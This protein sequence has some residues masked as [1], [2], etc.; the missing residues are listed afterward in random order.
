MQKGKALKAG[1]RIALIAPSGPVAVAGRMEKA[2]AEVEQMGFVPVL[3]K[4]AQKVRGYL[5]GTDD[6]RLNDLIW[7]FDDDSIDGIFCLKGGYGLHRIVGSFDAEIARQNPKLFAGFS[8][9]TAMHIRL[10]QSAG[11]VTLH[12]PMPASNF[13]ID[14]GE[15]SRQSFMQAISSTDALGDIANPDG[16]DKKTWVSGK[17]RGRIVGGNLSLI[18]SSI[19]TPDAIDTRGCLLFMEEVNEEPYRVDGMLCQMRDAGLFDDCA[20][21]IVGDFKLPKNIDTD[22]SLSMDEVFED[23]LS[24]L[25]CPV[26]S[27]LRAGHCEPTLSFFLGVDAMLDADAQSVTLLEAGLC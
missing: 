13:A 2:I 6:E 12:A 14:A 8:D 23:F 3:G 21:V 25:P 5:A 18:A 7:A 22:P 4:N 20:G 1:D 11:L 26:L 10:N 19:G 15:F 17:A 9:I 24:V 16:Y 27:G